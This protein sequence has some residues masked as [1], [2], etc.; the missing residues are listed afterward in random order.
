MSQLGF[1]AR[2]HEI[3]FRYDE[4]LT[5]CDNHAVAWV[6]GEKVLQTDEWKEP[7]V[8][9]VAKYL[10]P[11]ANDT[12]LN[13]AFANA[14][15]VAWAVIPWGGTL[16]WNNDALSTEQLLTA[17]RPAV[18]SRVRAGNN[19]QVVMLPLETHK[20]MVTVGQDKQTAAADPRG[21]SFGTQLTREQLSNLSDDPETLR[22]Q[23]IDMA[24]PGAVIRVDSFEGGALPNKSQIRSIR[25]SRDQFAA[26][27]A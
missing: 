9:E 22:Q 19:K 17:H 26:E 21:S 13:N 25:I 12:I 16:I 8:A 23:L 5:T 6:N 10:K 11:G 4:A 7:G 20:E 18:L 14:G 27:T 3:V 24:G 15:T 2:Q 1:D